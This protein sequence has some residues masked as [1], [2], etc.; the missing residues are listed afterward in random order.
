MDT[1]RIEGVALTVV[2]VCAMAIVVLAL[3]AVL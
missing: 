2:G 1:N 3:A